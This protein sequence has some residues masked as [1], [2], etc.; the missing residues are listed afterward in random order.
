[1]ISYLDKRLK[2]YMRIEY[3]PHITIRSYRIKA[4]LRKVKVGDVLKGIV[5][6][7]LGQGYYIL[8]LGDVMTKAYSFT[9]LKEK[10]KF[11]VIKN[12]DVIVLKLLDKYVQGMSV[13]EFIEKNV[14][15]S[16]LDKTLLRGIIKGFIKYN[17]AL[18]DNEIMEMY[19]L[20]KGHHIKSEKMISFLV[21][22]SARNIILKHS[23]VQDI[24]EYEGYLFLLKTEIEKLLASSDNRKTAELFVKNFLLKGRKN[25]FYE[26]IKSLLT[27]RF[28]VSP[29]EILKQGSVWEETLDFFKEELQTKELSLLYEYINKI[30]SIERLTVIP[31][32]DGSRTFFFTLPFLHDYRIYFLRVKYN[33]DTTDKKLDLVFPSSDKQFG[34]YSLDIIDN[35]VYFYL[36]NQDNSIFDRIRKNEVILINELKKIFPDKEIF[37]DYQEIDKN[38]DYTFLEEVEEQYFISKVSVRA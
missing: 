10:P 22:L 30:F 13:D 14:I 26:R 27:S 15:Y 8:Q 24:I 32:G 20:L 11:K 5:K 4:K 1:M 31:F 38:M 2:D 6:K 19:N 34:I 12:D 9:D 3:S 28:F 35:S 37:I 33:L 21:S 23:T 25:V 18:V 36:K 7:D 17:L 29:E 16:E